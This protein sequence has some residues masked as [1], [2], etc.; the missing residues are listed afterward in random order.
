MPTPRTQ[1]WVSL[2]KA[3]ERL[4]S[5]FGP[6]F[7]LFVDE[8]LANAILSK[9]VPVQGLPL[10]LKSR[11]VAI[12]VRLVR[13]ADHICILED[14]LY[15]KK[16]SVT[17][18]FFAPPDF[19]LV[20][21][22]WRKLEAFVYARRVKIDKPSD[23]EVSAAFAR[24]VARHQQAQTRPSR[25]EHIRELLQEL[26]GMTERQYDRARKQAIVSGT[27]PP[28]WGKSGRIGNKLRMNQINPRR[29]SPQKMLYC[30]A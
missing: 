21:L 30:D 28:G 15:L 29:K 23:P 4:C 11:R 13:E 1:K 18:H 6:Y 16:N 9:H 19:V 22:D 12:D 20:E 17:A 10:S 14:K 24:S 7:E 2:S 26:P 8:L 25:S 3:R 27:L 5:P